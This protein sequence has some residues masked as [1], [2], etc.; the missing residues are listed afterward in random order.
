MNV[1]TSNLLPAVRRF[2][3]ALAGAIALLAAPA[4]AQSKP[5]QV[6]RL[7]PRTNKATSVTG[8]VISD[9]LGKVEVTRRDGR[10]ISIDA[11][12]VIEIAWGSGSTSFTDGKT[13]A[14]R[15]A[16]E[17]AVKSFQAAAGDSEVRDPLRAEA[18]V[19]A[20]SAL[21][22]LAATDATRFGDVASECDRFLADFAESRQVPAMRAMKA[23]AMWLNGDAAGARDAYRAL[24]DTGKGG[25]DGYSPM[26]T[27]DAALQ[28]AYAALGAGDNVG[29]RELFDLAA[30]AFGAVESEDS[31]VAAEAAAGAEVAG[32]GTAITQ[33]AS[34]DAKS[35]RRAFESAAKDSKTS[36]GVAAARLGL[37]HA[38]LAEGDPRKAQFEYAWVAG[39]DHT[40]ADRRAEALVGL[41]EASLAAG[42]AGDAAAAK[43]ALRRVTSQYGATPSARKAAQLLESL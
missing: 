33:A 17:E 25:A 20:A 41:A 2:A 5:D 31:A 34:G 7:N 29:A 40:S 22:A 4:L 43:T 10:E 21:M 6:F 19:Q 23:R 1:A 18:R 15:G 30:A 9:G 3:P 39:L 13:Y 11:S 38:W 36:A 37:G 28:G 12:E 27:A 8:T 42:E 16:W 14:G 32:M 26:V 24:H 35:A